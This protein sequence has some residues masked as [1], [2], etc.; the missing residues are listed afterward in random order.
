MKP[1]SICFQYRCV[2]ITVVQVSYR[3][4]Q[5]VISICLGDSKLAV[6]YQSHGI[7]GI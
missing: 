7:L 5:D 2:C 4:L 6:P 3:K 1:C